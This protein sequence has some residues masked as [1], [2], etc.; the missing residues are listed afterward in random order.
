MAQGKT[1]TIWFLWLLV[2]FLWQCIATAAVETSF[3]AK[4]GCNE[5]C[6]DVIVPY[7]YGIDKPDCAKNEAFLLNCSPLPLLLNLTV[8]IDAASVCY[9]ETGI[10]WEFDQTITLSESW[11]FS[12]TRNKFTALG[13]DNLALKNV[14]DGGFGGGCFSF[15]G[16]INVNSSDD[17]SCS[18]LGCCQTPIPKNLKTLNMTLKNI[19]DTSADYS[20]TGISCSYAFLSDSTYNISDIDLFTDLSGDQYPSS[21]VVLDWVVGKDKCEASEGPSGYAC[22]GPAGS[23][24]CNY[25]YNGLGY[26]CLCMEG[27]T[28]NPYHPQGCQDIDECKDPKR[29]SCHGTCKNEPGNYTC[30]CPLGMHGDGKVACHGVRFTII[31]AGSICFSIMIKLHMF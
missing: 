22:G 21:P 10:T 24:S 31:F 14:A 1:V 6:G 29:Y 30:S 26:R 23:T 7:P 2:L 3:V 8:G 16:N 5:T 25:S 28:G 4:S 9:N 15:C 17:G 13:C 20:P 19:T 12:N 11:T 18:G 27:Y